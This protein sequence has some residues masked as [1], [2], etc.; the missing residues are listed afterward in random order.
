MSITKTVAGR[1]KSHREAQGIKQ[2]VIGAKLAINQG[3]YS[4]L[5]SGRMNITLRQL[6]I[7]SEILNV[8]LP[9]LLGLDDKLNFSLTHNNNANGLVI[10]QVSPNEKKLYEQLIETLQGELTYFKGVLNECM[11]NKNQ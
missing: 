4:K 7:I 6:E 2:Q 3:S 9:T 1:I 10:N 8:P 11:K 5:E